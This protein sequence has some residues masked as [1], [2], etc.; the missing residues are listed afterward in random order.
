MIGQRRS[1]VDFD[2]LAIGLGVWVLVSLGAFHPAELQ[3]R[4]VYGFLFALW[5]LLVGGILDD[6][7]AFPPSVL[8][9]FPALAAATVIL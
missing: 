7:F 5:I 2:A 3:S 1:L 9:C 6:L 8:I 4:Q